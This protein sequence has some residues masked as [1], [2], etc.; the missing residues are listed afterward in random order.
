MA[1]IAPELYDSNLLPLSLFSGY[2]LLVAILTGLISY[3][4]LYRDLR[5]FPPSQD[6]RQRSS[7]REKHVKL[8]TALAVL[9]VATT[10]YHM[11]KYLSLSY[12]GW[13]YEMGENVPLGLWGNHDSTKHDNTKLA[14]GRWLKDTSLFRDA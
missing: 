10:W 2:F 11:F 13:A 1:P 7:N 5:A 12:R 3:D 8:F 14:L 4:V 9:S 6:T